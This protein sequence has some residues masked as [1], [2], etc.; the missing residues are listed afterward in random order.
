MC[1]CL[2]VCV[3]QVN[4]N[5]NDKFCALRKFFCW[6]R[7]VKSWSERRL[8]DADFI[9]HF[10]YFICLGWCH[11][12]RYSTILNTHYNVECVLAKQPRLFWRGS[13]EPQV[14][15]WVFS[16]WSI[17][18]FSNFIFYQKAIVFLVHEKG[19]RERERGF[20]LFLFLIC[21][22]ESTVAQNQL[23]EFFQVHHCILS[24]VC[25]W[26]AKCEEI[27][28]AG[29]GWGE[30][31]VVCRLGHSGVRSRD[32]QLGFVTTVSP[33]CLV[34]NHWVFWVVY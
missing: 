21:S 15:R 4:P 25:E 34:S 11:L 7:C 17:S 9:F 26:W 29:R 2:C 31:S 20:K 3:L 6:M 13:D 33:N 1:V 8:D 5:E 27:I 22:S 18:K 23:E 24:Q 10:S 14:G 30:V 19:E 16:C 12:R 32:R 28:L